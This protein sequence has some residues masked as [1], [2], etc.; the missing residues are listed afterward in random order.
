MKKHATVCN[1]V[2]AVFVCVEGEEMV[3]NKVSISVYVFGVQRDVK[4]SEIS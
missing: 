3:R 2:N 4:T 1:L